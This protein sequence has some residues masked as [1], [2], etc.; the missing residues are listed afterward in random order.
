MARNILRAGYALVIHN[1]GRP[2]VDEL[3]AEGEQTAWSPRDVAERA[4]IGVT[5]LPD[6]PHMQ[7]VAP[8]ENGLFQGVS[9]GDVIILKKRSALQKPFRRGRRTL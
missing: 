4:S 2:S 1:R 8:G 7:S 5:M 9:A 6:S 3:T